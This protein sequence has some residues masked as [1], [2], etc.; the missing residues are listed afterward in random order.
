[1]IEIINNYF[2]DSKTNFR[3]IKREI[4]RK[5]IYG[6]R[7]RWFLESNILHKHLEKFLVSECD[8]KLL[9][10]CESCME[11]EISQP[12]G[13]VPKYSLSVPSALQ[14]LRNPGGTFREHF[15][16]KNFLNISWWKSSF[17]V[18][19]VWFGNNKCWSFVKFQ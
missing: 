4:S 7:K 19:S 16:G 5:R 10:F 6:W 8:P 11:S 9:C 15:K 13:K 3:L 17:C 1:M 18:K 12:A 2:Y 14:C